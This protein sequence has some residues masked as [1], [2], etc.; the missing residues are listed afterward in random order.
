MSLVIPSQEA[1]R[2]NWSWAFDGARSE[3]KGCARV[4]HTPTDG[5]YD[6]AFARASF[7]LANRHSADPYSAGSTAYDAASS[8]AASEA[9][10][11][12]VRARPLGL[13]PRYACRTGLPRHPQRRDRSYC[14]LRA[15]QYPGRRR[16]CATAMTSTP[17]ADVV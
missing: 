12:V 10:S 14:R 17:S 1:S 2:C 9:Q 13:R 4:P 6:A 8:M 11:D 5:A 3:A 16:P 7:R 15:A